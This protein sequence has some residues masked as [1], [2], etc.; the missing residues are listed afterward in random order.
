VTFDNDHPILDSC[1]R[2]MY[3]AEFSTVV[4]T[5]EVVD[6]GV[7]QSSRRSRTRCLTRR[8]LDDI[9]HLTGTQ[10][11]AF[12]AV[13][14]IISSCRAYLDPLLVSASAFHLSPFVDFL[15]AHPLCV[16]RRTPSV[17]SVDPCVVFRDRRRALSSP[18]R[19]SC[20][21][22]RSLPHIPSTSTTPCRTRSLIVLRPIT[23]PP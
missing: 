21:R 15:S 11:Y 2:N 4:L 6:E 19:R 3:V 16:D 5:S 20:R 10:V 13:I 14:D 8:I 23:R 12:T 7:K 1:G 22:S 17:L 18:F 9:C